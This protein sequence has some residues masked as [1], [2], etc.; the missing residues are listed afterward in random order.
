M[1]PRV[2]LITSGASRARE[3]V[4]NRRGFLGCDVAGGRGTA[5]EDRGKTG[6]SASRRQ[7]ATQS[8]LNGDATAQWIAPGRAPGLEQAMAAAIGCSKHCRQPSP[9]SDIFE[10]AQQ[11]YGRQAPARNPLEAD[12][13]R[14]FFLPEP[15]VGCHPA[16][17]WLGAA[18]MVLIF[19]F[20]GFLA[21]RLLFCSPLAIADLPLVVVDDA[22]TEFGKSH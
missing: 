20:F 19:S 14:Y 21:S 11:F 4:H 13:S 3:T 5:C 22:A 18:A 8:S 2:T 1:L 17:F 15:K 7:R 6:Q 16:V 9:P 12:V 10:L